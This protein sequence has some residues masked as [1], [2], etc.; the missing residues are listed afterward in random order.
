MSLPTTD[1]HLR[2]KIAAHERWAREP[3]RSAATAPARQANDNR[4]LNAVRVL[5][6][7]L[8]EDELRLRAANLRSADAARMARARWT[9]RTPALE[10]KADVQEVDRDAVDHTTAQT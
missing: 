1:R 7:N 9:K 10:K 6:P 4:Y 8:P 3:D 2:A 5:H